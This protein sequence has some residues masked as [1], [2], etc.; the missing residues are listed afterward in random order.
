M[1]EDATA[2]LLFGLIIEATGWKVPM[3][4]QIKA[5]V[6]F[7]NK[8]KNQDEKEVDVGGGGTDVKEKRHKKK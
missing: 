7:Q 1:H 4:E 8:K 3:Y 2:G 6:M 5:S